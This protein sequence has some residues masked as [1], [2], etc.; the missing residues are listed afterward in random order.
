[1][2]ESYSGDHDEL[3]SNRTHEQQAPKPERENGM[4]VAGEEI[5]PYSSALLGGSRLD[6]SANTPTRASVM[7]SA[8]K[9]HG[10]N[11]VQRFLSAQRS[12]AGVAEAGIGTEDDEIARR[13]ESKAGGGNGLDPA[14]L[15]QLEGGLGVDLSGVRVHTDTEADHLARSMQSIAFTSGS[16]IFFREGSFNP[17]T[18]EGLKLLAHEATHTVQQAAGPVDGTPSAGGVSIS[19]PG[20]QFEQA[21]EQ[22]AEAVMATGE[23]AESERSNVQRRLWEGLGMGA[24]VQRKAVQR[25]PGP[26]PGGPMTGSPIPSPF[27]PMPGGGTGIGWEQPGRGQRPGPWAYA[28]ENTQGGYEGGFGAFH[29]EGDILGVPVTDD[30]LYAKGQFGAWDDGQGGTRYGAGGNAGVANWSINEGGLV[31]G[32]A[33]ALTA[34]AEASVGD[35]GAT[36]GAQATLVGG[37]MT[38]GGAPTAASDTDESVRLGLS[39]GVGL[40][41][42]LHWGD[43]D[44]DGNREYGL[45]ADFGPFSFDL[46][47][48]DPLG[49]LARSALGPLGGMLLPGGNM[50][51]AAGRYAGEAWDAA[52]Q[53]GS[54]AW[55]AGG[56]AWDATKQFAGDTWDSAKGYANRAYEGAG[57]L[58]NDAKNFGSAAW[59]TTK[60]YANRAWEGAQNYGSRAWEGAKNL[61]SAAYNTVSDAASSAYNTAS[62][63]ASS[64]YNTASNYAGKAY[65]TVSNAA[66][67]AYDTVSSGVSS[68]VDWLT[69]W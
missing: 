33:E 14:T 4:L 21:A 35:S 28:K 55:D 23:G 13:I 27:H 48:E 39:E 66:G 31:S 30:L 29:G 51:N 15:G 22:A 20:D 1:M 12:A 26:F 36:L 37:S 18:S 43:K 57:E 64:A 8:Q 2:S 45:G 59:D 49:T 17:G 53:F 68:A 6:G 62:D 9:T 44:K 25:W 34:S 10:N 3:R 40:A 19:D 52:K 47:T 54:E 60:D 61:G 7:Q 46:K 24:P 67:S 41:G 63:Y 56:R 5:V 11:A 38:F 32:Q 16:D 50:T 65:D 58:W 42:R 69:D